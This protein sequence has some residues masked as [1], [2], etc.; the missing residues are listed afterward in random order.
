[1]QRYTMD[2]IASGIFERVAEP[3]NFGCPWCPAEYRLAIP[4][5]TLAVVCVQCGHHIQLRGN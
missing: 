4:M 5:N 1:M 2:R 3:V